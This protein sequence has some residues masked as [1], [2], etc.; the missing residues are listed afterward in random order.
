MSFASLYYTVLGINQSPII[1]NI[2]VN[3]LSMTLVL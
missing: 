1:Q 2:R 3:K